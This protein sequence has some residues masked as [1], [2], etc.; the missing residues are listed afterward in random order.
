MFARTGVTLYNCHKSLPAKA[1]TLSCSQLQL[2]P[3]VKRALGD[4]YAQLRR[5]MTL[6]GAAGLSWRSSQSVLQGCAWSNPLTVALGCLWSL[7]VERAAKV[8]AYTYADDWYLVADR[9]TL[10]GS[11]PG[12]ESEAAAAA[13]V[14]AGGCRRRLRRGAR[15]DRGAKRGGRKRPR[16]DAVRGAVSYTHLTLPTIYSV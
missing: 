5:I 4:F 6:N 3:G 1:E 7:H 10:A 14:P 12:E 9:L 13:A 11:D 2:G 8:A 16:R 15:H